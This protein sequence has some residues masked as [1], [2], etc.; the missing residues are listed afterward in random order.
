ML[1]ARLRTDRPPHVAVLLD[2]TPDYVVAIGGAG[3]VGACV[4]GLNHTRRGEHLARD[5]TYTDVQLL[6]TEPRHLGLISPIEASLDLPGG[7]LVS[8]RYAD[9]DD[10]PVRS[11]DL[12]EDA[13]DTAM[14]DLGPIGT[15][16]RS[17][18]RGDLPVHGRTRRFRNVGL[19]D[20]E[21]IPR[22]QNR[23]AG[24]SAVPVN[25]AGAFQPR[26]VVPDRCVI[27]GGV[28]QSVPD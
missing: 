11:A 4:V 28:F 3:L 18:D 7:T 1:R 20:S 15:V 9:S 2:N 6:V 23:N 24:R 10:P 14:A 17:P 22:L 26:N 8:T 16:E 12:L 19:V 27:A 5:I 21:F 13:L 25:C